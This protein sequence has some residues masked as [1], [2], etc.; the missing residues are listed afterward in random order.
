MTSLL[1]SAL[2]AAFAIVLILVVLL[3]AYGLSVRATRALT[4][5]SEERRKPFACGETL[6]LS[7][8]GLP[9]AGMYW[10]VWRR[11]LRSFYDT[12]RDK[13]HTGILSDWLFWMFI[14][15][16]VLA[17]VLVVVMV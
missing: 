5:G 4:R 6:R 12:L 7:E 10:A 9:D 13:V 8:T 2:E 16:V 11:L 15:M 3:I 14:F 17:I 1:I